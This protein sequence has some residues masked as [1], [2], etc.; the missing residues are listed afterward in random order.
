M[1]PVFSR[2]W[3]GIQEGGVVKYDWSKSTE[4]GF[5][6]GTRDAVITKW[7]TDN[8]SLGTNLVISD[9]VD[10]I[11]PV[12]QYNFEDTIICGVRGGQAFLNV[13]R[14]DKQTLECPE[15]TAPCS[16]ITSPD[17]T[18]CY[19]PEE[20]EAACPITSIDLVMQ[21]NLPDF[22]GDYQKLRLNSD[23]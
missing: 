18:I 11:A 16:Q 9:V 6:S 20:H 3:K 4:G 2:V 19:P 1:E 10:E 22:E 8:F 13:T 12:T 21:K 14:V 15:G 23:Y 17:N 5:K 7:Q